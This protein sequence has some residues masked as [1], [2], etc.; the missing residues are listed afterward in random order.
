MLMSFLSVALG[1]AIGA[2]LRFGTGVVMLRLAGSGFPLAILT[3]NVLGSFL[4]GLFVVYSFQRGAEH[5]NLFVMTGILGGFTTFS[6]FSLEAFTLFE[7]GQF[8][9]AALYILLSVAVSIAALVLGV[10][11]ARMVWA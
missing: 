11:I 7:R 9:A 4:M 1:G 3:V 10:F 2:S 8:T 5:L 6:A